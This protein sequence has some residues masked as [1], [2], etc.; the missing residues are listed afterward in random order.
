MCQSQIAEPAS[1]ATFE[2]HSSLA[3]IDGNS[4]IA[5]FSL[6]LKAADPSISL[7][8]P[9]LPF[10]LKSYS[11]PSSVMFKDTDYLG[12]Y[13]NSLGVFCKAE[14][15]IS[16]NATVQFRMRLGNLDT[17]NKMEGK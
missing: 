15:I 4:V 6:R 7:N 9:T 8:I 13:H 2:E 1:K 12:I 10:E 3:E 14:N 11:A 5:P 17:V 16:A